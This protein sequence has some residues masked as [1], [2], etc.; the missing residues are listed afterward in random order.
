MPTN[1]LQTSRRTKIRKHFE[2]I[3]GVNLQVELGNG[4]FDI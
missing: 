4:F 3:T 1:V 2:E